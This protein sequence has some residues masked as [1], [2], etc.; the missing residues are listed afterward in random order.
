MKLTRRRFILSS[1]LAGVIIF[2]GFFYKKNKIIFSKDIEIFLLSYDSLIPLNQLP[3]EVDNLPFEK[4]VTLMLS[5]KGAKKTLDH[6]IKKINYDYLNG[7][8]RQANGWIISETEYDLLMLKK[9]YV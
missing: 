3:E 9:K 8:L 4:N 6:F 2:S 7:K 1:T 5:K